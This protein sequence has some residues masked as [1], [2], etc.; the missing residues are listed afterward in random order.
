MR[1]LG[2]GSV[3][4]EVF[5]NTEVNMIVLP[6]SAHV[7]NLS[8][9]LIWLDP[10]LEIGWMNVAAEQLFSISR[11]S[12]V[13]LVISQ[14][15][16]LS[17]DILAACQESIVQQRSFSQFELQ[18]QQITGG[19]LLLE[20]H[21]NFVDDG[22]LMEFRNVDQKSQIMKDAAF[23][24]E[25]ESLYEL[26]RGMAHEI[27][28]PLGGLYG[29]AQLL[30][31]ELVGNHELAEY[32]DVILAESVRLRNLVDRMLGPNNTPNWQKTN[33]HR[34]IERVRRLIEAQAGPELHIQRDYDPSIPELEADED[35]LM[36]AL[37]NIGIN[38]TEAMSGQ[39][40][41][42]LTLRTRTEHQMTLNGRLH[43]HVARVDIVDNG[44]GVPESMKS[45]IF[46]PMISGRA[47]G[48]GLGLTIA[49]TLVSRHQG[50]ITC[51]STPGHTQFSLF[52]PLRQLSDD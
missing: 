10:D 42:C 27:K 35:W 16:T 41:S 28:N 3:V 44:P 23:L 31:A 50:H 48:T 30:R 18:V 49:K 25:Q 20:L 11:K 7:D 47:E 39:K 22:L 34:L 6:E 21:V 15:F 9:A 43:R 33:I 29:A 13:G 40:K 4:I 14:V 37:L 5:Y 2:L 1:S 19:T 38:A 45:K 52:I 17:D 12:A 32:T 8:V 46:I 26:M 36:Q 24:A 51:A